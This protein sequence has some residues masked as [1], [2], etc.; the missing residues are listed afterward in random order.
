LEEAER[1]ELYAQYVMEFCGTKH[2]ETM[3]EQCQASPASVQAELVQVPEQESSFTN[4]EISKL[5]W[6]DCPHVAYFGNTGMK[7]Q[8]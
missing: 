2:Y 5:C 7:S 4:Y 6:C 8:E 1:V 3:R